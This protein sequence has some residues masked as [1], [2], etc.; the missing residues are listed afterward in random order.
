MRIFL[1]DRW[2]EQDKVTTPVY[3]PGFLCAQGLF[4]TMRAHNKKIF[5]LDEHIVRLIQSLPAIKMKLGYSRQQLKD[6]INK[7][8][9]LNNYL[10]SY[11]RLMV[12][13]GKRSAHIS[14]IVREYKPYR[15]E[16]YFS[17]F[18]TIISTIR[19]NELSPLA[20][21]KTSSRLHL[22]LAESEAKDKN[23]DEAILL[24]SKGNLCEGTRTNIFLVK[25][26]IVFTPNKNS[27]CL[28][29]ITR[30]TILDMARRQKIRA[31]EKEIR[32]DELFGSDEAFLTNSLIGV[33]PLTFT[34]NRKIGQGKIGKL[35]SVFL[36]KYQEL[37]YKR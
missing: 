25:N 17:G 27:G 36:E 10:S 20:N 1:D 6:I 16:K 26:K 31:Y 35:T 24:N 11:V 34:D 9:R 19:Q 37:A 22:L 2:L 30:E 21:I 3:E 4:E 18:R 12:W 8:L 32:P 14:V 7:T 23:A 28:L 13:Q 5:R 15:K 29:G 33:M